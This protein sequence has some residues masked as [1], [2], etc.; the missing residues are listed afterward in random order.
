MNNEYKFI[1][2]Y[3]YYIY[4]DSLVISYITIAHLPSQI[5][6]SLNYA[7]HYFI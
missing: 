4:F 1:N 3:L 2:I 5:L 7:S 6:Q